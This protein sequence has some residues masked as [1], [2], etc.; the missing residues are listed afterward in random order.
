MKKCTRILVAVACLA[1]SWYINRLQAELARAGRRGVG[2]CRSLPWLRKL[3]EDG[4][5]RFYETG[6]RCCKDATGKR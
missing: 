4:F 5:A 2:S 3:R 1:G 6:F